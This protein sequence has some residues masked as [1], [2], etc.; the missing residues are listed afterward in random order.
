[1]FRA[2]RSA[3]DVILVGA[4]TARAE[5]YRAVVLDDVTQRHRMASG[6]SAVPRLALV[7]GRLDLDPGS[8]MFTGG[9][10]P[11]LVFTGRHAIERPV[12]ELTAVAEVVV[13]GEARV[14]MRLVLEQLHLRRTG[15]VLVEGGP[16]LNGQLIAAGLIDEWCLSVAPMLVSGESARVAHGPEPVEPQGLELHRLLE[17]DGYL[18]ATYRRAQ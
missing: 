1:V 8:P 18:F 4:A 9:A 16:S 15:V 7:S 2:L 5:N 6:R 10:E 17:Q 13:A 3:A 11:P 12:P 14:D